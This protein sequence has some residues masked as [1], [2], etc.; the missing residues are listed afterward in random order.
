MATPYTERE[1]VRELLARDGASAGTAASLPDNTI[2]DAIVAASNKIDSRLGAVYTVP[3]ATPPST[4]AMVVDICKAL[5]AYDAD[6]TF[7]EVRDYESEMNPVYL[8]YKEAMDLLGQLQKGLATLPDYVPPDPDPGAVD[9]PGGGEVV[10][11]VNPEVCPA[12][13]WPGRT[14]SWMDEYY[15]WTIQ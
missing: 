9:P 8:R 10:G 7:R 6:L 13:L 1:A 4:P 5:A 15:G 14:R 11:V 12:E 2:D 3:F